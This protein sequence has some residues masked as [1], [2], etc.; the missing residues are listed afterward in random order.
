L[1]SS[2]WAIRSA[3]EAVASE[4]WS[5]SPPHVRFSDLPSKWNLL[6]KTLVSRRRIF[7]GAL[8]YTFGAESRG[9]SVG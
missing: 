8:G 9:C 3:L 5:T 7:R 2:A 4:V 6:R 1:H